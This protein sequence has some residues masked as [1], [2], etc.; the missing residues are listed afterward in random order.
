[1]KVDIFKISGIKPGYV[2]TNLEMDVMPNVGDEIC[3]DEEVVGQRRYIVNNRKIF[4]QVDKNKATCDR[5]LL[6][7]SLC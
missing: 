7:V 4:Y 1:M 2:Q 6:H 3:L 5:V